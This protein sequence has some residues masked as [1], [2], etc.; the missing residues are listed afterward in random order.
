ME[1]TLF[2]RFLYRTTIG[3]VL[4]KII[5]HPRISKI[6]GW[7]LDSKLSKIVIPYFADRNILQKKESRVAL[8]L[9]WDGFWRR[10]WLSYTMILLRL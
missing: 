1:D 9:Y 5:V 4:L 8:L 3:R 7:F 6:A 10:E 2:L